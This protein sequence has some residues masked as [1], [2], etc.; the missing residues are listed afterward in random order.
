ML[1]P[2]NSV[3][4]YDEVFGWLRQWLGEGAAV[5]EALPGATPVA[6]RTER[7]VDV[8]PA[9]SGTP[10]SSAADFET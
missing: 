9:L 10:P 8:I 2:K 5:P 4:W 3:Q 7:G 1:K 6:N